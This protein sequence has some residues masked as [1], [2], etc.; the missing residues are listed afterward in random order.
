MK[1]LLLSVAVI[2]MLFNAKE[3]QQRLRRTNGMEC[4]HTQMV[5]NMLIM[6]RIPFHK[7]NLLLVKICRY[8]RGSHQQHEH[9]EKHDH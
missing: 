7:K 2:G 6:K 9:G 5:K 8:R 4:A 3:N 1:K